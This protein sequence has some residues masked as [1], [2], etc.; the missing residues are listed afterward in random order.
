MEK[1]M[2][3]L[4]ECKAFLDKKNFFTKNEFRDFIRDI[5]LGLEKK[6]KKPFPNK[7]GSQ[8]GFTFVELAIVV[9]IIGLFLGMSF[10]K[11]ME[12][13]EK[14]RLQKVQIEASELMQNIL[15]FREQHSDTFDK[16]NA[17]EDMRDESRIFSSVWPHMEEA[18]LISSLKK[19]QNQ[20]VCP[21]S[22]T[23]GFFSLVQ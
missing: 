9:A 8:D 16:E 23:S 2:S 11:G 4:K 3:I 18:G 5:S 1:Q 10:S 21:K 19:R 20:M 22:C 7:N 14:S 6:V 13:L 12:L 15:I 17:S